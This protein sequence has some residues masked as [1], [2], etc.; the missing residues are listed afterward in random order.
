MPGA[1]RRTM[2]TPENDSRRIDSPW[3]HRP[4]DLRLP[5]AGADVRFEDMSCLFEVSGRRYAVASDEVAQVL[6]VDGL[7]RLPMSPSHL[8]GVT[9]TENAL[10]PVI[11]LE[12]QPT[13][14]DRLLVAILVHGDSRVGVAIDRALG[15]REL[16]EELPTESARRPAAFVDSVR[17]DGEHEVEVLSV[18][19]VIERFRPMLAEPT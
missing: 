8:L 1:L 10:L 2:N 14:R 11:A 7:E 16:G 4:E 17:S 18:D 6:E 12:A 19:R 3:R 9:F 15:F 13:L 5:T